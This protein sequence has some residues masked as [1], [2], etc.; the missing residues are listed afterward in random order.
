LCPP[1][2][3]NVRT[4]GGQPFSPGWEP[5]VDR[6]CSDHPQSRFYRRLDRQKIRFRQTARLSP[7]EHWADESAFPWLTSSASSPDHRSRIASSS[8]RP[9]LPLRR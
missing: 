1:D 8:P 6:S 4:S 3:A 9:L 7:F 5:P 2:P